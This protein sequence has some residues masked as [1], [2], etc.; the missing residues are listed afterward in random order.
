LWI[1]CQNCGNHAAPY[2]VGL[3]IAWRPAKP[4]IKEVGKEEAFRQARELENNPSTIINQV[5]KI[6]STVKQ[7]TLPSFDQSKRLFYCDA[8]TKNNGQPGKQETIVVVTDAMGKVLIEEWVG[9]KTNNEGELIAIAKA[10][11]NAP[12]ESVIL[13]DSDLSIKL[14]KFEWQTKMDHLK[15]LVYDA[16]ILMKS[17]KLE[18]NWISRDINR[19]GIYIEGKYSL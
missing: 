15:P 10:A 14:I 7:A 16:A 17:K 1:Q 11:K 4:F 3:K 12:R 2:T 8:G 18:L 13:S 9:D 6:I 5:T 19:A